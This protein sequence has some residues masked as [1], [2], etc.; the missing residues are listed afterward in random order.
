MVMIILLLGS[1]FL[2]MY[3]TPAMCF[4]FIKI[5]KKEGGDDQ[6]EDPYAAKFYQRYRGLLELAL[7]GRTIVVLLT[8]ALLAGAWGASTL[9]VREF[10][11]PS[12]RNQFLLYVDLPAA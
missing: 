12:D 7:H 2:S 4:W 5:K 6:A 9:L 1:W 10:F 3:M 8:V 11:G